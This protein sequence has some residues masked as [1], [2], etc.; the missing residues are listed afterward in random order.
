M[1]AR[2]RAGAFAAALL[3]PASLAGAHA[4]DLV[5]TYSASWAGLPAA[6]IRLELDDGAAAYRDRIEIRTM[7]LPRLVIRFRGTAVAAGHFAAS[8]AAEP[9]RYD[10]YYD[11]RK[12]RDRHISM[13]FVDSGGMVVAARGPGDTSGKP[14]LAASYRA[15]VVDPLTAVEAIRGAL[16]A[17]GHSPGT[18][19]I[20]PVYDGSRRFD[21]EGRVLP[22][23]A[24]RPGI[25]RVALTLRPIA[26]FKGKTSA[27]GDPDDA[28]RPVELYL[29]EDARLVPLWMRV[30][31]YYLPLVVRLERMCPGGTGCPQ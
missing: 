27:D 7:G 24:G 4:A 11:L 25:V 19:F 13:R 29:S 15:G 22:R 1:A 28:P 20:V 18:G 31:L 26:G 14:P 10:A 8:G 2:A 21:V 17:R 9:S 23:R 6:G 16:R 30:S 5:A 12:R 3:A